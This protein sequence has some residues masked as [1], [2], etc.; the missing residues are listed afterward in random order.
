MLWSRNQWSRIYFEKIGVIATY[1]DFGSTEIGFLFGLLQ[2]CLLILSICYYTLLC[3]LR[4]TERE[5][6][7]E[8]ANVSEPKQEGEIHGIF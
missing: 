2:N 8:K 3:K 1:L 5:K 6:T 7:I 4:N